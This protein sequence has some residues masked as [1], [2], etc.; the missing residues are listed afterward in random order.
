M[1]IDKKTNRNY[2]SL[3]EYDSPRPADRPIGYSYHGYRYADGSEDNPLLAGDEKFYPR[4]Q[5]LGAF[6][7]YSKMQK[8]F[9]ETFEPYH[10]RGK[11][12][13]DFLQPVQ[14]LRNIL[15]GLFSL[16]AA[17]VMMGLFLVFALFLFWDPSYIYHGIYYISWMLEEINNVV[18]GVTQILTTPLTYLFKMP[19]RGILT[20]IK[21]RKL[22]E[23][24]PQI[25]RLANE[26]LILLDKFHNQSQDNSE[27]DT[28]KK[29]AVLMFEVERKYEKSIKDGW[30]T[31]KCEMISETYRITYHSFSDVARG[32]SVVQGAISSPYISEQELK[33]ARFY[34]NY[35][36]NR[37]RPEQ[38]GTENQNVMQ[39]RV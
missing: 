28:Y 22:A 17:T 38:Q 21:G 31:E 6:T 11:V 29:I 34:F 20:A 33:S 35:F 37:Q 4:Y 12:A 39:G 16:L 32:F 26:A 2:I 30:K 7:P 36:A 15:K 8:D 27:T 25:Q 19:I 3:F 24:K 1:K 14:G 18:R 13:R 5:L 10:S 23:E 9:V